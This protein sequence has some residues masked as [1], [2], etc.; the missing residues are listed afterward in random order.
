M[1]GHTGVI[2]VLGDPLEDVGEDF[3]ARAESVIYLGAY[4]STG[5]AAASFALPTTTFAEQEGTFTNHAGR[6]QRF[7]PALDAPGAARP[8]WLVLGAVI[9]ALQ[10]RDGPRK[11]DEAF[12]LLSERV[13]AYDGITY[14][15]LNG[16]G[17]LINDAVRVAGD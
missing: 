2:V 1:A 14:D 15:T 3:G 4:T 11:A 17:A 10:G 6:V 16:V 7:W 9:G 12:R 13:P 5:L 8:A